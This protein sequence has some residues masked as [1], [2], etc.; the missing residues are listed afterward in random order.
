MVEAT[1]LAEQ[2]LSFIGV[3]LVVTLALNIKAGHTGIPDFGHAMFFAVG[4]I[5]V[6]N[7]VAHI[8]A[9]I[10]ERAGL[11]ENLVEGV[12]ANNA[13]T[14]DLL[15]T[16][17]FPRQPLVSIGLLVLAVV[18]ALVLGGIL[19]WAAS[20]P[21][22]RLRG[23][24]LAIL[25]LSVSEAL[26]IFATYTRQV[27]GDTPTVGLSTPNLFAWTKDP[28]AA[29]T[30]F[31][32]LVALAAFAVVERLHNSPAGRLLRAVRDDEDAARALGR[33]VVAARRDAMIIGSS[34]AA[35]AGVLY[36]LNPYLGG[37]SVAAV[38]IYNRVF[39]TFWP[40]ALMILG[41]MASNRGV[42]AAVALV[43]V[44]LVWPIRLYRAQLTSLLGV[45]RMG[46]DPD[47]FANALEYVFLGLLIIL[48][49]AYRPEGII[50]EKPSRTVDFE[51][52]A[53]RTG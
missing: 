30:I 25:L 15:N 36:A 16:E 31:T 34:L 1:V 50:P 53:R 41:G 40:W 12:L 43:G 51:K 14:L 11:G 37:G 7:F 13:V 48:V 10:A 5:V 47:A 4:G 38:S 27:M 26:R 22:L 33:D 46:L 2:I 44:T 8:A 18:L 20:L 19:G 3:Y 35:L 6:G 9:A 42:A 39:W 28:G 21:A 29:A 32:L 23:E 17:F 45:E 49:L 52:V 24:Y